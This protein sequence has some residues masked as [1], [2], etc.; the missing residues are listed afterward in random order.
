MARPPRILQAHTWYHVIARGID[1]RELFRHDRDHEHYLEL[2]G[3]FAERFGC[4]IS[5]YV[6]MPNHFHLFL[7]T[8]E[9][10]LSRAVQWLTT[11]Y[12]AWLNARQKRSGHVFQ[13]RFKAVLVDPDEWA[14]ALTRYIH[15]NPVRVLRLGLDKH[16]R[17]ASRAGVLPQA[18]AE[19]VRERM[20]VLRSFR[21]S[22]YRA[23]A[24]YE[25]G[26]KWLC[27][28]WLLER[29]GRNPRE[30]RRWYRDYCEQAVR[31]GIEDSLSSKVIDQMCLGAREFLKQVLDKAGAAAGKKERP[32]FERIRTAIEQ[33]SGEPWAEVRNRHGDWSRDLALYLMREHGHTLR[34][35]AAAVGI[36]RPPTAGMAIKRFE[37]RLGKDK[38]ARKLL[39]RVNKT[40]QTT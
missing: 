25:D 28:E 7:E 26:P 27:S 3:R 20:A 32:D 4:N 34:A 11:G 19:T 22:S 36:R 10:N 2:L 12:A 9:P 35:A 40:L 24:G 18:E 14:L 30:R 6:L 29:C 5:A 1:R 21:W 17:A 33:A 16:A 8:M 23:Y 38:G 39:E 31:E 15:L 13:G 37:Q